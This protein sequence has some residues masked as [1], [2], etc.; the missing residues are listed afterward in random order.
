LLVPH[1]ALRVALLER[2]ELDGAPLVLGPPAGGRSVVQ[3][4]TPEAVVRG[5]RPGLSLREATALCPA[6]VVL[7]PNPVREAD[8]AARLLERLERLSPS[9]EADATVAGCWY[10]DLAGLERH[11]GP[12]ETAA[13]RLLTAAPAILRPRVGV[14]PGKFAARLA[15]GQA[16]PGGTRTVAPEAVRSFL[17]ELPVT[18]LPLPPETIQRLEAMGLRTLGALAA[19]PGAKVAAR[20][21]PE[22][23]RAWEL[24]GGQDDEPVRPLPRAPTV[25]ERLELPAPATSRETLLLAL[26]R[27]VRR[28]FARPVL[29]GRAVRQA[30]LRLRLE[31]GRSWEKVFTL[32]APSGEARLA[33]ALRFRLAA[34]ELPG[35][36]EALGLHLSG[37]TAEGG[38]QENFA[39]LRPGRPGLF[40]LDEL[41]EAAR[42]LKQRYGVSPLYRIVAVEPWSRLPERRHALLNF[43]P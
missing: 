4:A 28:A 5:I 30:K 39:T 6:A 37:L 3:D 20:F 29:R 24:A 21:G 13:A 15:A 11:L 16:P 1:F 38:R 23:R 31:G 36:V 25:S 10:V 41:T 17:A 2:P 33:A 9:V 43:D 32:H 8:V 40:G 26:D 18:W 12:A 7:A 19:L 34:L 42:H 22:G 35:P 14:A 27:L